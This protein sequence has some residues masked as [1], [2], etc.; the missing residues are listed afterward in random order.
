MPRRGT[1][2]GTLVRNAVAAVAIVGLVLVGF[3]LN[4]SGSRAETVADVESMGVDAAA[5]SSRNPIAT[6]DTTMGSFTAELLLNRVP[7]TVS[8]FVDLAQSGF[9]TGL[10]FHRVIPGFMDQ[11]GCPYSKDPHSPRSGTGGPP[12]GTFTNLVTG[13]KETRTN[14]GNIQ[15]ENIDHTSNKPGTLSMANTGRANSGGSQFF[16]NVADN[17]RLDWFS[18][19]RSKHPVFAKIVSGYDVA[20]AISN[21]KT[22]RDA[23]VTPI[24]MNSITIAGLP[25]P[26]R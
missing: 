16:L 20:V 4:N 14:G 11:F 5:S 25:S 17:A 8:N 24:K 12:D 15:D 19:G 2:C 9:Y 18:G 6:F 23:P 10:H 1:S 7:R 22:S 3:S 21:V 26:S 13:E